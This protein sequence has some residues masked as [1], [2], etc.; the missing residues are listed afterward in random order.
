[1]TAH[2]DKFGGRILLGDNPGCG[3]FVLRPM[4]FQYDG[5]WISNGPSCIYS[6]IFD[7]MCVGRYSAAGI[8][9]RYGL[10]SPRIE[11]RWDEIFRIRPDPP[12]G[13]PS[14]LY[15]G[16]RV[17]P[18]GK[19]TAAWRWPPTPSSAEVKERV[20]LY[21]YFSGPSWPV[22]T[23]TLSFVWPMCTHFRLAR[24]WIG[25]GPSGT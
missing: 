20:E 4:R 25:T 6:Y 8:A 22:L 10:D 13:P 15:D 21:I 9:T 14:L 3:V 17:V 1:M 23:L 12:M 19:A 2:W 11:S 5:F 16:Y 18:G 24:N 7:H